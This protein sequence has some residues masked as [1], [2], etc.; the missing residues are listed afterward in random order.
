MSKAR[1]NGKVFTN[2]DTTMSNDTARAPRRGDASS[3]AP[4]NRNTEQ[5]SQPAQS[6]AG[7]EASGG[8]AAPAA[9]EAFTLPSLSLPK[10]GGAIRG[11]GEKF[12]VNAATGTG[13]ISVPIPST[14]GRSGF[15]PQLGLS[16]DSGSGNGPFGFGW[17]LGVPSISRKTDKGLP[18]YDDAGESDVFL[19]SGTE[20]LVPILDADNTRM[21][22]QRTVHGVLY[23]IAMY[24]PRTEGL[25]SRIERWT[26]VNTGISHWRS[27]TRD[28]VT[29][30]Y[31]LDAGSRIA[32]PGDPRKVFSYL[33]CRSFDD[34]G[35][36]IRYD[37]IAENETGVDKG[38]A[39]EANRTT[40]ARTT[41]RYLKRIRYG[42]TVPWF[43]TWSAEGSEPAL[44]PDW[45]FE[46]VFDYG[47]H[48]LLNPA[49]APL[50]AWPVRPDPFSSFRAGFEV[51]TYRRCSRVLM[52]H[53]FPAETGIGANCLV[54]STDFFYS[55][56]QVPPDPAA[57][58]Y[59]F[60]QSVTQSGYRR[61]GG[62]YI[63]QSM[64][65]VEFEYSKPVVQ[66]DVLRLDAES[67][68]NLPE[69]LD[70]TRYQW[71]DLDGEGVSGIL[72]DFGDGWGYK[73]NL[74]PLNNVT[75][76][77]GS[78]TTRARFG[79]LENVTHLPIPPDLGGRLRLMDLAGDGQLDA[80][81]LDDQMQ[82]FYER[83]V[84]ETWS[85]FMNFRSLPQINWSDPNLRLI[86]L[87]GDGLADAL[88]T[89]D[90]VF[91]FYPSLGESGFGE[92]ARV[93]TGW[94]EERGPRA[95]FAD[96]AQTVFLADMSGDGLSDI[97]RVRNGEICYWPNLGYGRFG[98]KVI[99]DN[100]PRFTDE[101][102][103]DPRRI[104]LS[105]I[106]GSGTNDVLYI[107]DDGVHVCFNRSGNS[108]A[109][110]QRIAVFPTADALSAVQVFDLLG[111]GTA[112]LVW[113]SPLP[114]H[115]HA[116]LFYV[117]LMGGVKP[118]LM[119]CSR[120][121]LGAE[122]RIRYAP[123]TKF[124][125]ADRMAGRPWIT[126]LPNLVHVVERTEIYDFI[127]RSR[128]VT[129]YAYHHG[130]FD[131][132]ER[133]FRGF[134]MVEQWDTEEYRSDTDFPDAPTTNWDQSSWVPPMHTRTWFHTGAFVEAGIVSRQYASEYWAEPATRGDSPAAVAAREA[135]LLPDTIMPSGLTPEE[136]REAYRALKGSTLRIEVYSEDGTSR[137]EHPYTVTEQNFTVRR[138]QKRG[139]N[140][141]S[142]FFVHSREA[143]QYHYERQPSD[144]RITHNITLQADDFGNVQQSVAVAYGRRLG[145][146]DPEP[147]LSTAFRDMLKH[148]QKRLHIGASG[149]RFTTPVNTPWD[150]TL[151]DAYRAPLPCEVITAEFT[152]ITPAAARFTFTEISSHW[153]TLWAGSNDIPYEQVQA[154][155]INGVSTAAGLARRIVEHTQMLY[156]ANNL[157]NTLLPLGTAESMGLPGE[158]Y[159]LVFTPGL[160]SRIF[161]TRVNSTILAEGGY[162]Q[163]AGGNNW[164]I[165]SGRIFFSP[166]DADNS[167]T[168]LSHAKLH[169]FQ[170]RRAVDPFN[171][172]SRISFDNY[173]IL[174]QEATDAL[175]NVTTGTNDYR[176]MQPYR[177]VDPNGNTGEVAFDCLGT[178]V[179][180]AVYG[181]AG[182][183]DSL[184]GFNPDL[185]ESTILAVR[186]NPLSSPGTL[187][188]NATA[189][190]VID[191]LAYYRTRNNPAP[192]TPMVYLLS[193]ETHVSDLGGGTTRYQH[194]L[195]YSDGFGREAQ[196]KALAEPG[197]VPGVTGSVSPR[198]VGSGWTIFNNKGKA[199]RQYEPFFTTTH[200]FEFNHQVGVSSVI[201]YDPADRIVATL[202]PDN[203]FEKTVF[204]GWR[205]E[206]WDG[207]DTVLIADPRTDTH[208][209]DYFKRLLGTAP[210]AFTSWYNFRIGGA[211]GANDAE[212]LANKDAAQKAA[213]HAA[214]PATVH[215]DTLG[216]SSLTVAD[217]GTSG[218]VAQRYATRTALDAENKPL[219]VID[220]QGR[221]V[222]EFCLREA[223]DGGGFVYVAGYSIAGTPLY[224]NGMDGGARRV[225]QNVHGETIRIWDARGFTF[226]LLYDKLHRLTHRYVHHTSSGET[227]A[228]RLIYGEKHADAA[229]NL[230]GQLF[231]HYDSGGRASFDRYDFK[232][233]ILKSG[234]QLAKHTPA[235]QSPANLDRAPDW[236]P[237]ATITDTPTLNITALDAAAAPLL[238]ANDAF[239]ALSRFDALNRPIQMVTPHVTGG[240]PSVVQPLYNEANLLEAIDVWI[241]E[242]AAPAGLLPPL[243]ADINAV[244]GINYNARG[245]RISA[246]F[247][248]G[249]ETAYTYDPATF[250]LA[251]LTTT[252]PNPDSNARTVQA[253]SYTY[254]P[255]GNITRLRDDAD[256]HNVIYFRNRRVDPAMNYTY[257][258]IYRLISASGREHL[259]LTGTPPVHKPSPQTT[260]DDSYR[261]R[262][263]H[264]GD[265]NAVGTYTEL[266]TYDSV[267]NLLK[268]VHQVASGGWTR[269]YAYNE[270]S[271]VTATEKN[272]RLSTTSLPSDPD[273]GPYTA[274]YHYDTHGNMT[275]MPH[276]PEMTWDVYDRLQSTT[277]QV[278]IGGTP[279]T[280]YYN[281]DAGGERIR[282]VTYR[283]A[284]GG[285]TPTRKAERIYL[286]PFE[287]YREYNTAGTTVVLERETLNV[288]DD[289]QRV[290]MVETRTIDLNSDPA[291]A[292]MIRYQYSNHLGSAGLE[293]DENAG[294]IS[295][296][297][298][299]P[300]GATSYHAVR[301]T[302]D[303]PKRY[304]YTG[305]ERDE[306]NDLYYHGARYYAP[307]LG[308]WTSCDPAGLVDGPNIYQYV[309]GNPIIMSDPTG[310]WEW[311]DVGIAAA[312][313]VVGVVV[314][315]ATAGAAAPVV[316]G[317]AASLGLTGATATIATVATVGSI[318][319]ATSGAASELTRQALRGEKISG[320]GIGKAA[321]GGALLGGVT[322]G[323]GAA[324]STAKG[325]AMV[326]R[327]TAAVKNSSVGKAAA[328]T[329]QKAGAAAKTVAQAPGIKQAVGAT[330]SAATTGAKVVQNAERNLQNAGVNAAKKVYAPG[331]KGA[332]AVERF[333]ETRTVAG[334][335]E[336]ST[337]RVYRVQG[338][339]KMPDVSKET[340]VTG[341]KGE[342]K[343]Q[344]PGNT[345]KSDVTFEDFG[346]SREYLLKNRPGAYVS[347]F[348]VD[349]AFIKEVRALAIPKGPGAGLLDLPQI[350]DPTLTR[351][352]FTLPTSWLQRLQQASVPGTNQ[353]GVGLMNNPV[354]VLYGGGIGLN[355]GTKR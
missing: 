62:G 67:L 242:T 232:G 194:L 125:I 217:N 51:R 33:I 348:E 59:T 259:G 349:P 316:A 192:D 174:P 330:K 209:R 345:V 314:T 332:Q 88:I 90:G 18:R 276:L 161:G 257:D 251:T 85:P 206:T 300:Y 205:Q 122:T 167:S 100:A 162:V 41:Q 150:A 120:N 246:M 225:L 310:M 32:D 321:A 5:A 173:D 265:G 65:P 218:G 277:R 103:F 97:V 136:L 256:I 283:Q 77:D 170:P 275:R 305:K 169:F 63:S 3:A 143:L 176:V 295:Y 110:A 69:G 329:A 294:V 38:K 171:A 23:N 160:I 138:I 157:S 76:P 64:P 74:S 202:H 102:R 188:G 72:T 324:L 24:R 262:I 278:Y 8:A 230:K 296:E 280:T 55:D 181:K 7:R 266:Y 185:S 318:A 49:P 337:P 95:V 196:R 249:S 193:R 91:T 301:N 268:M 219:A 204:D 13:S 83:T 347:S 2:L 158:S 311:R 154:R 325:A 121:N 292:Q 68:A 134:G 351:S 82:G 298:Y 340:L 254:D 35:N 313:V 320:Q 104:R 168:E 149:N 43:P 191:R 272:N 261:M 118:H 335:F 346:R 198:W 326:T 29:T 70:G 281:Y 129:R 53:H 285:V 269:R 331:S 317:A 260:N 89:E 245:Q 57:P 336:A 341:N 286:G 58:I 117:D 46:I 178:V 241:R 228:E 140:Q 48:P 10:G 139:I 353:I 213:A 211:Y 1:C 123:S 220:A 6:S 333:D 221:H 147:A 115:A 66:P 45:H 47:D 184:A 79:P 16:Y 195:S 238:D 148:D 20:D 315:V 84:D 81:L 127:G 244:L 253:L 4:G 119:I 287:I 137:A 98:A 263:P 9:S 234:R 101:E 212:K 233:N 175:G 258:A 94:D 343:I 207:N 109:A 304:R 299:F 145:Y 36:V 179:G 19:L 159:Q 28:N 247:G 240:K 252:R 214:T 227:L 327:A 12:G 312:V 61:D 226:R 106:D 73:R 255:A 144:P 15:G 113:S 322:G 27:I 344:L 166:G 231:R 289:T 37:Y 290:L 339:A 235:M 328:A 239:T 273:D 319:G 172:I 282:K 86:D 52:F 152:G 274:A 44:P 182:E 352:S 177:S 190:I 302:T 201:F 323:A 114:A 99:T 264:P 279:E 165:P 156:R 112:C 155:D 350:A 141:H 22:R 307:W 11:I 354:P 267:G 186:S 78:T 75:L 229:L 93:A 250:R 237:I 297:E 146:T 54:S 342:M 243:S 132:H 30:L 270:T 50:P 203:T 197:P 142:V 187:L 288:M 223:V 26:A 210:G 306:E 92:A 222:M 164:W 199:V 355:Q 21:R 111:N 135:L 338:G 87:T 163:L 105:D 80:V 215:F 303:V 334:T 189:R 224:Q 200:A 14:P 133:E 271:L 293:L 124:Y 107:G 116:P 25:F 216:R 236:S 309:S 308:R 60:L 71:V 39:H 151:F 108:W 131:G 180:T 40:A 153:N 208:V 130:Y 126:R 183:G 42:N 128:F 31:G 34:K 284:A 96:I 248:N 56:E 17:S 291:P